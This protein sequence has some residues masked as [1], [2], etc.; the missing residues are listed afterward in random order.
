MQVSVESDP[1]A[2]A[3]CGAFGGHE[4][5]SWRLTG[6]GILVISGLGKVPD[7]SCGR[8]PAPPWEDKKDLIRE[9][10]IREGIDEIGI[11]AFAGCRNL[12]KARLPETLCRIDAYAFMDCTLLEEVLFPEG[13]R[14]CHVY[15]N[16]DDSDDTELLRFGS[17]A[18]Y[19][20]PWA[21]ETWG[22][23]YIRDGV[24]YAL[25]TDEEA[26]ELPAGVHTISKFAF[27]HT[28]A[29]T[30]HI[31]DSVTAINDFA[32][33]SSSLRSLSIPDS[34]SEDKIGS[35]AFTGTRLSR[36]SFPGG[37]E[38]VRRLLIDQLPGRE[39]GG[40]PDDLVQLPSIF[41]I[42]LVTSKKY[43]PFKKIEIRERK[44][45]TSK[46]A[47]SSTTECVFGRRTLY[48][49]SPLQKKIQRGSVLLGIIYDGE[50]VEEVSAYSWNRNKKCPE[51]YH[52]CPGFDP[53]TGVIF[54]QFD[55]DLGVDDID[56]NRFYESVHVTTK[57]GSTVRSRMEGFHEE[58]FWSSAD[59]YYADRYHGG[60][61]EIKLLQYWIRQ[62]P[63]VRIPTTDE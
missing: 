29:Q 48:P 12:K 35:Y 24:L 38:K 59:G 51:D 36:V 1:G 18:F 54:P 17:L 6:D 40:E 52:L 41:E 57:E 26:P 28:K 10:E 9:I 43:G 32:F 49:G 15:E 47:S 22:K 8:N 33:S 31:P 50:S 44:P 27:A 4:A 19:R 16:V 46:T 30:V 21:L 60:K 7:F 62:H 34:V 61:L 23:Y 39:S 55:Y 5:V 56:I 11:R 3:A 58:W 37:W 63:E 14:F 13:V 53:D 45:K 20:T 25:L 42:V 2:I